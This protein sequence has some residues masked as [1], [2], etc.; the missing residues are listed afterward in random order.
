MSYLSPESLLQEMFHSDYYEENEGDRM[1]PKCKID[2]LQHRDL[3]I[4]MK[5][6]HPTFMHRYVDDLNRML[7]DP[8]QYFSMAWYGGRYKCTLCGS[9]FHSK[10]EINKHVREEHKKDIEAFKKEFG[11]KR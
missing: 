2:F 11:E 7:H 6:V 5:E 4:H 10:A 3:I 9:V 1:C 8:F